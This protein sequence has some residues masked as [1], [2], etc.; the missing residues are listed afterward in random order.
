M[1]V[2]WHSVLVD[3]WLENMNDGEQG[4]ETKFERYIIVS[5]EEA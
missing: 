2:S 3:V 4:A 5:V 1:H